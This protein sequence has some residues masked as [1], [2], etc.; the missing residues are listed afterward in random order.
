MRHRGKRGA[1]QRLE[2]EEEVD[3]E[4][5]ASLKGSQEVVS[6]LR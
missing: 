2:K 3:E 5:A 1:A 6:V 4:E